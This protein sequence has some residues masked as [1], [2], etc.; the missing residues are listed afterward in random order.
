MSDSVVPRLFS[1]LSASIPVMLASIA[2]IVLA[3][4]TWKRHPRVSLLLAI[5]FTVLLVIPSAYV[6]ESSLLHPALMRYWGYGKAGF[7]FGILGFVRSLTVAVA[8]ALLVW[9]ALSGR[10][11]PGS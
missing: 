2:G 3:V 10:N 6:L 5:A 4:V 7:V 1:S 9:A 11:R 8:Y